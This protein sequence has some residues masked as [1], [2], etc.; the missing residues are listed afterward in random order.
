MLDFDF[1]GFCKNPHHHSEFCSFERSRLE[2]AC[3]SLL[4]AGLCENRSLKTLHFFKCTM[5]ASSV[6]VILE[7]LL[8]N[9]T[10]EDLSFCGLEMTGS[11]NI[12]FHRML[13]RVFKENSSLAKLM[14][15]NIDFRSGAFGES[16]S[17]LKGNKT[18]RK[19]ILDEC[20][21]DKAGMACLV[22]T[23]QSTN[24]GIN[25]IGLPE[26]TEEEEA[27]VIESRLTFLRGLVHMPTI[28]KVHF[29]IALTELDD[30]SHVLLLRAVKENKNIH[31]FDCF[32]Y[33]DHSSA[34]HLSE[35]SSRVVREIVHYL[36]LNRYGRRILDSP[37]VT[38]GLWPRILSPMTSK[39]EDSD[40][41]FFFVREYFSRD[42]NLGDETMYQQQPP[43]KRA[44][45]A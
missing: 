38:A 33:E 13:L 24:I 14:V 5:E 42:G 41:L 11:D 17:G 3:I 8:V 29:G 20:R 31:I 37:N 34:A 32:D 40:A 9:H 45:L 10:L 43:Q 15:S 22:Q 26:L 2:H 28:Q 4:V 18:L 7:S 39:P 6:L 35:D 25:E 1:V 19:L 16:L 12:P 44:R 23:L 36:K 30:E 21:I 27:D